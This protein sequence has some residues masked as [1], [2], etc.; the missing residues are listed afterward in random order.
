MAVVRKSEFAKLCNVSKGRVTQWIT[1]GILDGA[2][3]V[4][5]GRLAMIDVDIGRAQV[6]ERRAVN[7]SC[8]LNGL[9]T[10]LDYVVESTNERTHH[11]DQDGLNRDSRTPA[12]TA[13]RQRADSAR[14]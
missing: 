10:K 7:E 11:V 9:N 3:L 6:M 8:G 4:G 14:R 12:P 13:R 5:E 1:S 2:A